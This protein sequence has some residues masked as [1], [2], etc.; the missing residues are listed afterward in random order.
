VVVLLAAGEA[1]VSV[2]AAGV[3]DWSVVVVEELVEVVELGCVL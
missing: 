2:L 1:V 3:V